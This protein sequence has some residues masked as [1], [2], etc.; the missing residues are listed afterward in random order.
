MLYYTLIATLQCWYSTVI[1]T[2]LDNKSWKH[3]IYACKSWQKV[4]WFVDLIWRNTIEQH[5]PYNSNIM[6]EK[7]KFW[8]MFTNRSMF[9]SFTLYG[10]TSSED[11][12]VL[13]LLHD[14]SLSPLELPTNSDWTSLGTTWQKND[15]PQGRRDN[16]DLTGMELCYMTWDIKQRKLSGIR[17]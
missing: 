8:T 7:W 12:K 10:M 4:F 5:I 1:P 15:A 11:T 14:S 9:S 13:Q 16:Q 17:G 6:K 3:F 2:N